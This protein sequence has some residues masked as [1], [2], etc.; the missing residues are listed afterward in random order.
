MIGRY[1]AANRTLIRRRF[2][3]EVRTG[4][5]RRSPIGNAEKFRKR[6]CG[7]HVEDAL[8]TPDGIRAGPVDDEG[9]RLKVP[10]LNLVQRQRCCR[11]LQ[12]ALRV[13]LIGSTIALTA[14]CAT[15]A[16]R[17]VLP[18]AIAGQTELAGFH[19]IRFWG[20]APAHEIQ[21]IMMADAPKAEMQLASAVARH[22][23]IANLLAISGGAEDGPLAPGCWPAGAIPARGQPS[24]WSPASAPAR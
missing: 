2:T 15:I 24:I 20:D 14:G 8:S 19:N 4:R 1:H 12:S 3:P 7:R 21:A 13:T 17:N 10:G 23:P 22:P 11:L 6:Y 5:R 18:Q 9:N 16:P